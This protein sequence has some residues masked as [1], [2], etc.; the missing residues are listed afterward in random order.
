MTT[1]RSYRIKI[2]VSE[3]GSSGDSVAV[4]LDDYVL[5]E[6]QEPSGPQF[7]RT[8]LAL[9]HCFDVIADE[10]GQEPVLPNARKKRP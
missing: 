10:A 4:T 2:E 9:M 5:R 8:L 1:P 6:D 7:V 3:A